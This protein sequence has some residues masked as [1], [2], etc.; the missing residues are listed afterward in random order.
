MARGERINLDGHFHI[1]A[2]DIHVFQVALYENNFLQAAESLQHRWNFWSLTVN[3]CS[4]S[5]ATSCKTSVYLGSCFW[6]PSAHPHKQL[7]EYNRSP[8][9]SW[10]R[11]QV[12][13]TE[14]WFVCNQQRVIAALCSVCVSADYC[15]PWEVWTCCVRKMMNVW[16]LCRSTCV[17][18]CQT[19]NSS[20]PHFKN[21]H[22]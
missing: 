1:H 18:L 5:S 11:K 7:S 10:A 15:V 13:H 14:S 4:K 6:P 9:D 20:S 17:A 19:L 16:I 22:F 8:R 3:K 21:H 12:V 2:S